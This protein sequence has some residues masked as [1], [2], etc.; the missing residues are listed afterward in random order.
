MI[1]LEDWQARPTAPPALALLKEL[2]NGAG[3]AIY[4]IGGKLYLDETEAD[5]WLARRQARPDE[6]VRGKPTFPKNNPRI[7]PDAH[8]KLFDLAMKDFHAG[9]RDYVRYAEPSA[10]EPMT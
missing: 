9:L 7:D 6:R 3:P 4:R 1:E 10:K 2:L 8:N 5:R